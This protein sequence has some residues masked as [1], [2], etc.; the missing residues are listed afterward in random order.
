MTPSTDTAPLAM[1]VEEAA[2][3]CNLS[4]A[5]LYQRVLSGELRSAKIGR[6]RRI[7]LTDLEAW[8]ADQ[9]ENAIE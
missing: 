2:R 7:L 5:T 4:R 8:I 3:R 1:T 6:S 9:R